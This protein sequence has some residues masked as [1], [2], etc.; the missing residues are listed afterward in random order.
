M[1]RDGRSDDGTWT[2]DHRLDGDLWFHVDAP[3]G[4][5]SR[6]VTLQAQRV[7]D[8]WAGTQPVWTSTV[9]AQ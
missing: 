3:V 1:I 7:L 6:W 9:A 8:W 4:E 2:H 5:P